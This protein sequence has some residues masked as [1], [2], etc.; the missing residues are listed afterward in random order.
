MK[1][2]F[3]A[4]MKAFLLLLMLV[5]L[6]GGCTQTQFY[7]QSGGWRAVSN[8]KDLEEIPDSGFHNYIMSKDR[9]GLVKV[10]RQLATPSGDWFYLIDYEYG[11]N[12]KLER[13][14]SEFRTFHGNDRTAND[15]LPTGC[16]RA[17][18]VSP[19][20]RISLQFEEIRDLA[21]GKLVRRAFWEPEI[22]HWMTTADLPKPGE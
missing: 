15:F 20:G 21:S 7:Y 1:V 22:R 12:G 2:S 3:S 18:E 4:Q 17:Y 19:E 10:T 5:G 6:I 9:S 11:R 16:V 8:Q 13:I 14:R